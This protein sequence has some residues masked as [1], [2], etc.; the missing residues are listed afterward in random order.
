MSNGNGETTAITTTKKNA[1]GDTELARTGETAISVLAARETAVVQARIMQ[2][3]R[4]PRV[5]EKVRESFKTDCDRPQFALVARYAKPQGWVTDPETNKPIIVNGEKVRNY[6]RGWSIRA[7]ESAVRAMGNIDMSATTIFEDD[8]KEIVDCKVWDLQTNN[9]QSEQIT[10]EK[11]VERR[12][13]ARGQKPIGSRAN[14]YGDTV[15]LVIATDDEMRMKRSRLVSMKLRTLGQRMVP[16]DLLDEFLEPV[17]AL[18]AKAAADLRE[19]IL[20]DP[21]A[22]MRS[23]LDR[24]AEIGIRAGDVV[25]YLGGRSIES[26]TPEMILEMRVIGAS[27]KAG[28]F[29]WRDALAGSP[30]R[31]QGADDEEPEES[32]AAKRARATIS[33]K[34][35]NAKK[36]KGAPPAPPSSPTTTPGDGVLTP[37]EEARAFAGQ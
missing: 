37:E 8:R 9:V 2:A 4:C 22:A 3:I 20:K 16:G 30:Y 17:E 7:I 23:L 5:F 28:D 29:S 21:K 15:Y 33:S 1:M 32:E 36:K 12:F 10:V 14:S 24:L 34:L 35:E 11:T 25:E 31:E 13:L 26:A 27:V 18:K 6:V 19:G